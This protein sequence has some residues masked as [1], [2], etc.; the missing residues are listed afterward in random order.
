MYLTCNLCNISV[1]IVINVCMC[2]MFYEGAFTRMKGFNKFPLN[3]LF[4]IFA[5]QRCAL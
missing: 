2:V 5:L 4:S 3:K 1:T